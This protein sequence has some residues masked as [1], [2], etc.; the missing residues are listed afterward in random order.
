[1][2]YLLCYNQSHTRKNNIIPDMIL[3]WWGP[4]SAQ[5]VINLHSYRNRGVKPISTVGK[6]KLCCCGM[7]IFAWSKITR[8]I[9]LI[10]INLVYKFQVD[11]WSINVFFFQQSDWSIQT[12]DGRIIRYIKFWVIWY[13]Q[14]Y[15]HTD[16]VV[17]AWNLRTEQ[18]HNHT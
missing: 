3:S 11:N 8:L 10:F 9:K 2:P 15:R 4:S 14:S 18:F 7:Q 5:C 12:T 1:M 17:C 13:L 6:I 16:V